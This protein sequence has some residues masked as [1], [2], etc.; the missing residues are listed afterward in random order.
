MKEWDVKVP[1]NGVGIKGLKRMIQWLKIPRASKILEE[2]ERKNE[3][4][5]KRKYIDVSLM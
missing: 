1:Q 5:R 4:E 3:I 2:E